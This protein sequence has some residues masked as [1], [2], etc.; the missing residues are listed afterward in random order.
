MLVFGCVFG[1]LL[2]AAAQTA[3]P[4]AGQQTAP[5]A[6]A[7]GALAQASAPSPDIEPRVRDAVQALQDAE[8]VPP[9]AS[10]PAPAAGATLNP[11]IDFSSIVASNA[12]PPVSTNATGGGFEKLNFQNAPLQQVLSFL[13]D[14]AGLVINSR[15]PLNGRVTLITPRPMS[16]Q[17]V[18][19]R[20]NEALAENGYGAFLQDDLTLKIDTADNIKRMYG[21]IGRTAD[22][23]E[24]PN[25]DELVTWVLPIK[26]VDA[27]Q[28]VQTLQP[29]VFQGM[30]MYV[31]QGANSIVVQ[32]RLSH[33]HRM[34]EIISVLDTSLAVSPVIKVYTLQYAD[35]KALATEV[36]AL[37]QPQGGRGGGGGVGG[38][39][40]ALGGLL[41]FG[42]GFGGGGGG[43]G[44]G[45]GG[46]GGRSDRNLKDNFAPVDS[47]E[48]LAKVASLPITSWN[49]KD[50]SGTRHLG[51][52][53]QD[54]HGAF[55]IGTDDKTITFLDEGG[56]ALAAIQGLNQKLTDKD[57]K[58]QALE[59]EISEL[60]TLIQTLAP[61]S[62]G[63][64]VGR[65]GN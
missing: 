49:Y 37:F 61:K 34:A 19:K 30:S 55:G 36:Q 35:A 47:Q 26:Y 22:P 3:A 12:L 5:P 16:A 28:L 8:Q 9:P 57:A 51:P 38:I 24:I 33:I 64:L 6:S 62:G 44:R 42:G 1:L 48:V 40:G 65:S 7:G 60:K 17:E 29:L 58:F 52:M 10:Q 14:A 59:K 63:G 21:Q 18:A 53:A 43:G 39:G 25:T 20:L 41:N 56:V 32:D 4:P 27:N 54:F 31:S 23:K 46:G 45:G 11:G 50:D 13:A 15:V 2:T